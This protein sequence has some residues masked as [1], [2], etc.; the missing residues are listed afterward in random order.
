MIGHLSLHKTIQVL[1]GLRVQ[2]RLKKTKT[3]QKKQTTHKQ[4]QQAT[5]TL[6]TL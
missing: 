2:D 1:Q 3:K 6:K 5:G 4:Q